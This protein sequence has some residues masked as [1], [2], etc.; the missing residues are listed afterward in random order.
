ME[1]LR[2]LELTDKIKDFYRENIEKT[3]LPKQQ[4]DA[5]PIFPIKFCP[6][7]LKLEYFTI[8]SKTSGN[9]TI[10]SANEYDFRWML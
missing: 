7:S 8:K 6:Y 2:R 3:S 9:R 1:K 10:L 4:V 5:L